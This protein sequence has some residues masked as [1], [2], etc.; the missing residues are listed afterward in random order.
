MISKTTRIIGKKKKMK[1]V[2]VKLGTYIDFHIGNNYEEHKFK[3]GGSVRIS[4]CKNIF[5][6]A[7]PQTG[8]KNIL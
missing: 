3:V 6:I 5:A 4:R 7:I 2:T 8:L 1:P